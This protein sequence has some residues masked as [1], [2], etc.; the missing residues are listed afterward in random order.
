MKSF[1]ETAADA[2]DYL[3]THYFTSTSIGAHFHKSLEIVYCLEGSTEFSINGKKGVL[4]ADEMYFVPSYAVHFNRNV[5]SNT[6]LSLIFAHNFF[7]D[8]EKTFPNKIFEPALRDHEANKGLLLKMKEIHDIYW[9]HNMQVPFLRTQALLDDLLYSLTL[10]YPLVPFSHKKMDYTFLNILTYINEHY[11]ED[12]TLDM[13]AKKYNYCPQYFSEFF[14]KTMGCNLNA[15]LN[16]IRIENVLKEMDNPLTDKTITQL[17][18]DNGFKS[19][20]TFYRT[21]QDKRKK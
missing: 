19:L 15:Y 21:L 20:S 16:N 4:N 12:I 8:F 10:A 7:H 5:G 3:F 18:F 6:I 2:N 14:N 13:L 1:Y 17:A 9:A 11:T